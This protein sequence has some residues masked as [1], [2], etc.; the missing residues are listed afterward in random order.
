MKNLLMLLFIILT[1]CS[2]YYHANFGIE[3]GHAYLSSI[4]GNTKSDSALLWNIKSQW[5][6]GLA[7]QRKIDSIFAVQS[8]NALLQ[9]GVIINTTPHRVRIRTGSGTI[10]IPPHENKT[11]HLQCG[12]ISFIVDF[13]DKNGLVTRTAT[14]AGVIDNIKGQYQLPGGEKFDWIYTIR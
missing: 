10:E 4:N 5:D 6:S 3:N 14:E 12:N 9:R 11:F 8:A 7:H 2:R 1:G 13:L